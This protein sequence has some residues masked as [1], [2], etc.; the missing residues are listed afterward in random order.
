MWTGQ[1]SIVR[2]FLVTAASE[3]ELLCEKGDREYLLSYLG[4]RWA[5][6]HG[7]DHTFGVV[8]VE[9][10]GRWKSNVFGSAVTGGELMK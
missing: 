10:P 5:I 8:E 2:P 7:L 1:K 9:M 3:V 4:S 6:V